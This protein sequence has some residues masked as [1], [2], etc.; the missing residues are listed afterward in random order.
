[1]NTDT[2]RTAIGTLTKR[3]GE[4][5][6]IAGWVTVR[7]DHGKLIFLDLRDAS[8]TI[9]AVALPSHIEARTTADRL[10]PEWV[11]E[12]T[13][14]VNTRPAKMVNAD[15]P[16]GAIELELTALVVLNDA[17][18]PVFD[19]AGEGREIG[20]ER[21]LTHRYLDLRRKRLR[22][23]LVARHNIINFTRQYFFFKGFI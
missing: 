6:K 12:A 22:A 3:V 9:Q 8:G 5:G 11:I 2:K 16:N 17:E 21:R 19:I 20:E 10:R 4:E 18:T 7:R 1:M 23:N 13:G 15:T 14:K